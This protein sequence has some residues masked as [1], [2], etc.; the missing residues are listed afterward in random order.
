[1]V[2]MLTFEKFHK[3]KKIKKIIQNILYF[4][5]KCVKCILWQIVNEVIDNQDLNRNKDDF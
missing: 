5:S 4:V 3:T 1:M 2:R